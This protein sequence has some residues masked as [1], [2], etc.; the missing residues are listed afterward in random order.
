MPHETPMRRHH[1]TLSQL[2]NGTVWPPEPI[3]VGFRPMS[4]EYLLEPELQCP[5]LGRHLTVWCLKTKPGLP[6]SVR[7]N[8]GNFWEDRTTGDKSILPLKR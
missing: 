6:R 3:L 4:S 8:I 7:A 2:L 5:M 1:P